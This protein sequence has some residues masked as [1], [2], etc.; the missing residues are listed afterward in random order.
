MPK[1]P[2]EKAARTEGQHLVWTID[3]SSRAF[4]VKVVEP[5]TYEP[6][7][8]G[9][10][11]M[12]VISELILP[13]PVALDAHEV[14]RQTYRESAERFDLT[15]F[16]EA[17]VDPKTLL[18]ALRS[19]AKLADVGCIHVGLRSSAA[20]K[21]HLFS[22]ADIRELV[23]ELLTIPKLVAEDLTPF[24]DWLS[25]Q[26]EGM[27]NVGCL[28]AVDTS[29]LR[30]CLHPKMVRSQFE[31][32]V[33]A[34]HHMAEANL[35]SLVTLR[36]TDLALMSVVL[37][38]I[39][40]SDALDLPTDRPGGG[41]MKRLNRE[42]GGLSMPP[43]HVDLVSVSTCTPQPQGGGVRGIGLYRQ[44][45]EQFQKSFIDIAQGA[46]FAR[47]HQAV[48]VLSNF[49]EIASNAGGG[50]SGVFVP[51]PP[52]EGLDQPQLSV[53][54]Y[55]KHAKR[56]AANGWSV[57]TDN[58]LKRWKSRGFVVGLNPFAPPRDALVKV[59]SFTFQ[60][61]PRDRSQWRTDPGLTQA[62]IDSGAEA[63]GRLEF[64]AQEITHV[65]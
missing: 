34:E 48:M 7:H 49:R 4:A 60:R 9:D 27:F 3:R 6:E 55:G 46:D 24:I 5:A 14:S 36:P 12:K 15:T 43:D 33:L 52:N 1:S 47:H 39:I 17:F 53:S 40:C 29:G 35:V 20:K 13:T 30:V 11:F 22:V 25:R 44:W 32:H 19:A 41:P 59:F 26:S 21:K 56:G 31:A 45:H 18:V 64:T 16:P 63:E 8:H 61:L 57:P 54:I 58:A 50:L 2:Q 62:Q 65:P 28:F 37:Q 38:P 10:L 42:G 51:A 23:N